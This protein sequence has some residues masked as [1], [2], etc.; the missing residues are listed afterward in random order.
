MAVAGCGAGADRAARSP[1]AV[2]CDALGTVA[3]RIGRAAVAKPAG[4]W[5]AEVSLLGDSKVASKIE[6]QAMI[7][8]DRP[9]RHV[10]V[11]LAAASRACPSWHAVARP[12][13]ES[14][15]RPQG[16][17]GISCRA[18]QSSTRPSA[19]PSLPSGAHQFGCSSP[20]LDRRR[21]RAR[22]GSDRAARGCVWHILGRLSPQMPP[23]A[24][25]HWTPRA[26]PARVPM[27][28]RS[29]TA[30]PRTA[31]H[32]HAQ[33]ARSAGASPRRSRARRVV[34]PAQP[35]RRT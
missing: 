16:A 20:L 29:V 6:G 11:V 31:R 3:H 32:R 10:A 25:M 12:R 14:G 30:T 7:A 27:R 15:G 21:H 17:I 18:R 19:Q 13:A 23:G 1:A 28:R 8:L 24:A 2:E 5:G 26:D 34:A 22:Q 35:S 4:A 9:R 33:L